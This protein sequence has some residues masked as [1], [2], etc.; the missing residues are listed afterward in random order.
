[1]PRFLTTL[2]PL[3]VI[4]FLAFTGLPAPQT[5]SAN[6]G[7]TAK[8]TFEKNDQ[9]VAVIVDGQLFTQ[10]IVRA[11]TKPVLWPIN[12]PTGK[13]MTR[14]WPIGPEQEGEHA[15]HVHQKS[16]WLTHEGVNGVNYWA[17]PKSYPPEKR[18]EHNVGLID[19]RVFTKMESDD[20]GATLVTLCDW[21]NLEYEPVL[22]QRTVY[23]FSATDDL[24]TI[25]M[26]V[27]LKAV[28]NDVVLEDRKDGM[29]GIR[30]AS[31]MKVDAKQGGQIINSEGQL[32]KGAW[33]QYA[34]WVD[35]HGPVDGETVGIAIL[36]HPSNFRSPIRWHVRNYGLFAANPLAEKGFPE[37]DRKQGPTTIKQGDTLTLRFRT[38]FHRGDQLQANIAEAYAKYAKE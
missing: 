6:E 36:W 37:S 2:L 25:D 4:S 15:D 33:G 12:G 23:R 11:G 34:N 5:V 13:P 28:Q 26:V 8:I 31:S 32:D 16:F 18:A 17:E 35:Y 38:L 14:S 29:F 27:N 24:R 30:V 19:H 1:M 20:Q 7:K 9:G 3:S 21:L 22:E 10:Y